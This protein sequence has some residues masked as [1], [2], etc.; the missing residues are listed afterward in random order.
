MAAIKVGGTSGAIAV[1]GAK[2]CQPRLCLNA[3]D[4]TV[5]KGIRNIDLELEEGGVPSSRL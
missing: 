3:D 5:D 4:E 1:G 2:E